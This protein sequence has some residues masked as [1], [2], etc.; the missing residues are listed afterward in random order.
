VLETWY[1]GYKEYAGYFFFTWLFSA[2]LIFTFLNKMKTYRFI[3]SGADWYI[4]LPEFIEQ[5]GSMDDLQMV[6]GA[7]KM[8]DMMAEN[9]TAVELNIDEKPFEGADELTLTERCDPYIGGGYYLMKKYEGQEVNR[10]MWLCQVTQFVFDD[11]PPRI[12]V[13]RKR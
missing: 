6:E 9:T 4:D 8:L 13:K 2:S 12:F 11:I 5:G 7:D 1:K 3:K 10:T